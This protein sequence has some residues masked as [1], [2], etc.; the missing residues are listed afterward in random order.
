VGVEGIHRLFLDDDLRRAIEGEIAGAIGQ[1]DAPG[2]QCGFGLVLA[3]GA[4][5]AVLRPGLKL[6]VVFRVRV[7]GRDQR[8][9]V[10]AAYR[11][12]WPSVG[13]RR[14]APGT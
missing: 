6:G 1:D 5:H 2:E 12:R 10:C 3:G 4:G 9:A 11:V 8:D 13:S 7:D 14:S